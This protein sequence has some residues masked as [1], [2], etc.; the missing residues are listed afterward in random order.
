MKISDVTIFEFEVNSDDDAWIESENP[1]EWTIKFLTGIYP[2][3]YFQKHIAVYREFLGL[4]KDGL[5]ENVTQK[6]IALLHS[7]Y[8]RKMYE[9]HFLFDFLGYPL[10]S[11]QGFNLYLLTYYN[12]M[13]DVPD[14]T[15]PIIPKVDAVVEVDEPWLPGNP[16]PDYSPKNLTLVISR[17][18][19]VSKLKQWITNNKESL[20]KELDQLPESFEH[21]TEEITLTFEMYELHEQGKKPKEIS[22][23]LSDKYPDHDYIYDEAWISNKL[24]RYKKR[25]EMLARDKVRLDKKLSHGGNQIKLNELLKKYQ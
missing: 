3:N 15:E 23:Q 16:L 17:K 12:V 8:W 6:E 4:P 25:N 9:I 18:M 7:D 11:M 1:S 13:F 2:T 24:S 14:D 5:S 20:E 19:S 22:A 10:R 21:G